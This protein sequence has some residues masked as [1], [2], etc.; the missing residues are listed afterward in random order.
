MM[1]TS[2]G[3]FGIF[4]IMHSK[5]K[6]SNSP[7]ATSIKNSSETWMQKP[8]R[9]PLI[10]WNS[11]RTKARRRICPTCPHSRTFWANFWNSCSAGGAFGNTIDFP[12]SGSVLTSWN[13][14]WWWCW[15]WFLWNWCNRLNHQIA[16]IWG[17]AKH[18]EASQMRSENNHRFRAEQHQYDLE[19]RLK[20]NKVSAELVFLVRIHDLVNSSDFLHTTTVSHTAP[21]SLNRGGWRWWWWW[22]WWWWWLTRIIML[23]LIFMTMTNNISHQQITKHWDAALKPEFSRQFWEWRLRDAAPA[24]RGILAP[25]WKSSFFRIQPR[26]SDRFRK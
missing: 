7:S 17:V 5:F 16:L 12:R 11:T 26:W 23:I 6:I 22:W 3:I 1:K 19:R 10:Y 25:W 8:F 4:Y 21:V 20:Q 18:Y 9:G 14:W 13:E 24:Q 15:S 2:C